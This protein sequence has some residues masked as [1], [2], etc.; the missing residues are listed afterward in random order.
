MI[1]LKA[2]IYLSTDEVA[3]KLKAGATVSLAKCALLV[4]AEAKQLLS[5]GG[6]QLGTTPLLATKVPTKYT[7]SEVGKPPHLRSG[8]LR[9]SIRTERTD[10]GSYVIGP[11]TTALYGRIHEFGGHISVTAKM[12][13][14]LGMNLGIW[15]AIGSTIHIPARPFMKPALDHCLVK[16]P[17]L[18]KNIPLGGS[19]S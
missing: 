19:A 6:K 17:E 3:A 14:W 12:R 16:F 11:T 15:K 13:G 2:K 18:F 9:A 7:P 1:D 10:A 4:E 8:N 5:R